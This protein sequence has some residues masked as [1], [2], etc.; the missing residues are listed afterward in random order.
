[1]IKKIF[2]EVRQI[3]Q[4]IVLQ[5]GLQNPFAITVNLLGASGNPKVGI[6]Y[7][8]DD[9]ICTV[10]VGIAVGRFR[11]IAHACLAI[12]IIMVHPTSF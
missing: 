8:G 10:L 3:V 2:R 1:M 12:E 11:I 5:A 6:L 9:T 4:L 7:Y